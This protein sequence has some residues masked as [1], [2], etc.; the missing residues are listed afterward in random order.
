MRRAICIGA[1]A[2]AA[3]FIA[4][5]KTPTQPGPIQKSPSQPAAITAIRIGGPVRIAPGA[6]GQ[7]TAIAQRSDGSSEDV[8]AT[9]T[10][11]AFPLSTNVLRF[12]GPGMAQ[13]GMTPGEARVEAQLILVN[14]QP[15]S[16]VSQDLT[17]LVLEPGTFRI[18]GTV[19]ETGGAPLSAAIEIVSGTGTG[20]RTTTARG[21]YALYGVAGDVQLRAFADGFE[22]QIHRTVVTDQ[23]TNDFDLKPLVTP[24]DISGSWILTLRASPTCRPNLPEVAWDRQ[25]DAGITQQ[26]TQFHITLTSPTTDDNGGPQARLGRIFGPALSFLIEGNEDE[27]TYIYPDLVDRLSPTQWLAIIG[28][29]QAT[30]TGSEIRATLDGNLDYYESLSTATTFAVPPKALCRAK[31][32]GMV[33]RRR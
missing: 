23:T 4:C 25:F 17:V 33:F 12:V 24:T 10:W 26:G 13:A 28:T 3:G 21:Q 2:A 31:D 18:S 14:A 30:V 7:F 9:V 20:L 11:F 22:P 8:T 19:T 32:H 6:T 29:V 5:G 27:G 16:R 1:V 15:S